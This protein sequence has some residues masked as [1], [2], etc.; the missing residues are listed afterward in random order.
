[1][2]A[3]PA[4][5]ALTGPARLRQNAAVPP[6]APAVRTLS[7]AHRRF[8]AIEQGLVPGVFN[9][10]LNA[11]IAWA[12]FRDR[13]TVPFWGLESIAADTIGTAFFLP[14]MT[15][16]VVTLQVRRHCRRGRIAAILPAPAASALVPS[17]TFPRALV[18]GLAGIVVLGIPATLAMRA[19]GMDELPLRSFVAVKATIAAAMALVVT[20][21]VALVALSDADG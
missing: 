5:P 16:L 4:G 6:V 14:C 2:R 13:T 3:R 9:L 11:A 18:A 19:L 17:R 21:I 10:L 8:L 12:M 20:P 7:P 1:M 15:T